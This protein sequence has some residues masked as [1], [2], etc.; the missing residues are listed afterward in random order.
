DL[1][2]HWRTVRPPAPLVPEWDGGAVDGR[3]LIWSD[4]ALGVEL[5]ACGLLEAAAARAGSAVVECDPRMVPLLR[6]SVPGITAVSRG[7]APSARA[8]ATAHVPMT[9]LPRLLRRSAG[10]FPAHRGYLR[11]D[12]AR[13]AALRARYRAAGDGPLVGLSWRSANPIVGAR[14]S[15]GLP[16]W[17][18][19]LANPSAT[20]V[21]LQYGA[22]AAEAASAGPAVLHDPEI[23]AL[24]DLDGFAA[25]VAAM[26]LVVTISNSTA[27]FA[28]A[29]GKPCWLLLPAGNALLW[30][31]YLCHGDRCPWYP[32][33][34]V[35][36]WERDGGW[37]GTVMR[38]AEALRQHLAGSSGAAELLSNDAAQL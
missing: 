4:Q 2:A 18:P 9:G 16:A 11:A 19:I 25:Q 21:S 36:P 8:A 6:R 26:D 10:S 34:R 20:F 15:L 5:L 3:L 1:E 31:W 17:A 24:A 29:L 13:T 27:H 14:K 37:T 33:I 23:N 32:S 38:A 22:D 28:G 12:P 35:F 7:P 30:C